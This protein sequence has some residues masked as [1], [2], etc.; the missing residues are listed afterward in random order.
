[1]SI[2]KMPYKLQTAYTHTETDAVHKNMLIGES[3]Q[4]AWTNK[5][6]LHTIPRTRTYERAIRLCYA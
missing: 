3:D 2:L 6:V 1:M 4:F 5:A